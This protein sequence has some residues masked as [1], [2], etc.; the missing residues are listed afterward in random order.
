[1]QRLGRRDDTK[2]PATPACLSGCWACSA[3]P[4]S[5]AMPC[6]HRELLGGTVN[7]KTAV[8]T[9]KWLH[10]PVGKQ[11]C[12]IVPDTN[13]ELLRSSQNW[14]KTR[15]NA[16]FRPFEYAA[17][18]RFRVKHAD[19]SCR[20]TK[21]QLSMRNKSEIFLHGI[22]RLCHN[23]NGYNKRG[24]EQG[25]QIVAVQGWCSHSE[26]RLFCENSL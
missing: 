21:K 12:E 19:M 16:G 6:T 11:L 24:S 15:V 2:R 25:A 4:R 1:M 5:L 26:P 22:V 23:K 8:D 18:C 10:V 20:N 14:L 7:L 13:L 9:A 3:L 17:N